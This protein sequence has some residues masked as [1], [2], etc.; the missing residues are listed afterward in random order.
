MGGMSLGMSLDVSEHLSFEVAHNFLGWHS[1]GKQLDYP[2]QL[3]IDI[4]S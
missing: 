2:F 4:R 3:R 1:G